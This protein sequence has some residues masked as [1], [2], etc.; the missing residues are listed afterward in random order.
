M[1]STISSGRRSWSSRSGTRLRAAGVAGVLALLAGCDTPTPTVEPIFLAGRVV[2]PDGDSLFAVTARDAG[3][4]VIYDR[5]G[6]LRDT[7]G[8]GLLRSPDHVQI[9]GDAWYV[10]DVDEGRPEVV[11]L[12]RDGTLLRRVPL[13]GIA[14]HAHQFAVLPDGAIVVEGRDGRLLAVRGD[15][16]ATFALVE[17]GRRPSLVVGVGGGVL[18]AVPD[19]TLTLYNGFGNIRWRVEW[20]WAETAFVSGI[21]VDSHGRIQI[22]A[23]VAAD[24]TFIAYSIDPGTGEV[25]RWSAPETDPSF[26]VDRLGDVRRAKGRW[27][28]Q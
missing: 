19:Q 9:V 11:V 2:E 10:S 3:A 20:P 5:A 21:G 4:L 24:D 26:V 27:M 8:R 6:R 7:L 28:G 12:R 15:S 23:G 16:V 13:A 22:I 1:R 18:L 14:S 25:V 17:V